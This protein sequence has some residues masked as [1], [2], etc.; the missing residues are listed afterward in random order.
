MV[1]YVTFGGLVVSAGLGVMLA[2]F[3]LPGTW[4]I[5][6]TATA[7]DWYHSWTPIGW[8]WLSLLCAAA[9]AAELFDFSA[10]LIAARRAGASR[11]AA[12]GALIGG[13]IGMIAFSVPIPLPGVGAIVG[14]LVGCF[15]GALLAELSLRKELSVGLRIGLIATIGRV[16]GMTAKTTAA[17]MIGG[18]VVSLGGWFVFGS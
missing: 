16:I 7:Y 3:Q 6:A 9:I 10:G 11:R 13:F 15:M 1:E 8:K 18:S 5:L 4:L 14:G 12:F 17:M 2:A